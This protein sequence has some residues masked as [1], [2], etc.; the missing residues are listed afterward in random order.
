M[1]TVECASEDESVVRV[2][3]LQTRREGTIVDEPTRLVD[4]EKSEDDPRRLS[5]SMQFYE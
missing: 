4:D 2:E 5:V 3:L 1:D